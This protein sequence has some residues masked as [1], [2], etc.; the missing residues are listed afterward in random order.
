MDK[1]LELLNEYEFN[2]YYEWQNNTN[3]NYNTWKYDWAYFMYWI[4]RSVKAY[5]VI[6][7]AWIIS[8]EYWFIKWLVQNNK[9]D[10]EKIENSE[11]YLIDRRYYYERKKFWIERKEDLEE[12]LLM[13]LAISDSP[14]N[15]LISYL[16]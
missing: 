12:I 8:K 6:A 11:Y 2:Y 4:G 16:R 5:W 9:I 1:L 3:Y 15:D 7:N 10:T 13:L 14:V